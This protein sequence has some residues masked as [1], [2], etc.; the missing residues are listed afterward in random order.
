VRERTPGPADRAQLLDARGQTAQALALLEGSSDLDSLLLRGDLLLRDRDEEQALA[1]YRRAT[2]VSP[3]SAAALDGQAR[4]CLELGRIAEARELAERARS[5]LD[6][7]DNYVQTGPVFLT[8]VWCLRETR[9]F[10]EALA[11]AEEGLGR[12]ND[13]VLA[14]WAETIEQELAEAEKER[15]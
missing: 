2:A 7:G 6:V 5:L 10:R 4:C 3:E 15:C 1:V 8:L 9:S 14:Q 11:V 12:C 13:A